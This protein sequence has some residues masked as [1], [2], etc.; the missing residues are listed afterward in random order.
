V[1]NILPKSFLICQT[2]IKVE[3]VKKGPKQP[4]F[5]WSFKN[6]KFQK[7]LKAKNYKFGLRE[8]NLATL[9]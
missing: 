3:L 7:S 9:K 4:N 2:D 6:K 1:S 5:I 8:A